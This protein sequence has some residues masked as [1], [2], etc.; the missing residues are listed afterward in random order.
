MVDMKAVPQADIRSVSVY[1]C[2]H[3]PGDVCPA[4]ARRPHAHH[5]Q[6]WSITPNTHT[7][8]LAFFWHF[9]PFFEKIYQA[10]KND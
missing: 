8:F 6:H 3:W 10:G 2:A 1:R 5:R 9:C 7:I 4:P